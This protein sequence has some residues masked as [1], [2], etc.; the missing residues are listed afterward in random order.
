M[1]I[2]AVE[3]E[4]VMDEVY[5]RDW[6]RCQPGRHLHQLLLLSQ[7]RVMEVLTGADWEGLQQGRT[8]RRQGWVKDGHCQGPEAQVEGRLQDGA[9]DL[10]RSWRVPVLGGEVLHPVAA[11]LG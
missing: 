11:V 5:T 6:D 7:G 9:P 4:E 8:N 1:D 10:W 2:A 3:G